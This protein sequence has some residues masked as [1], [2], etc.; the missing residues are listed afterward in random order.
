MKG[1]LVNETE[2]QKIELC[3]D[4]EA[5]RFLCC[6]ATFRKEGIIYNQKKHFLTHVTTQVMKPIEGQ[7]VN[8]VQICPFY[9]KIKKGVS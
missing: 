6:G 2:R 1:C 4:T 5:S 7:D 8:G 3:N 9:Y